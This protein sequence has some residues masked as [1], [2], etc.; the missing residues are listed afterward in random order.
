MAYWVEFATVLGG[1]AALWTISFAWATYVGAVVQNNKN[2]F[3]GLKGV[4]K[5]LRSELEYIKPWTGADG[6]GYSKAMRPQ[7]YPADWSNPSRLIWTFE[8]DSIHQFLR[9]PYLFHMEVLVAPL[10][11]LN[12][13]VSRLFQFYEEYR[14]YVISRPD[15]Y[16][17]LQAPPR[18]PDLEGERRL[19][20]FRLNV[21]DYNRRIHIDAIGGKDSPDPTCLYKAYKDAYRALESFDQQLKPRSLPAWFRVI[22]ILSVLAFFV[23][24]VLLYQFFSHAPT[25]APVPQGSLDPFLP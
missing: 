16:D 17:E 10:V 9:S 5:S 3:V 11:R 21:L 15:L 18:I 13:S 4:L 20:F 14:G 2:H 25:R 7:D 24:L 22:H 1:I 12:Y 19:R 8:C 23:G 6:D